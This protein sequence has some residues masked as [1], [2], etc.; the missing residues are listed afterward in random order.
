M[1][2]SSST[3]IYTYELN[4]AFIIDHRSSEHDFLCLPSSSHG[5]GFDDC[6]P[7]VSVHGETI[8]K[9]F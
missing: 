9:L 5:P 3:T 4:L 6:S 2:Y 1:V 7:T 8:S